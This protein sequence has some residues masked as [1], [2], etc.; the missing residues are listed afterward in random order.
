M[1]HLLA[2]AL[3]CAPLG[4]DP[5][6]QI[7]WI[8]L[9]RRLQEDAQTLARAGVKLD[10]A[11]LQLEKLPPGELAKALAAREA[12]QNGA[13]WYEMLWV[14]ARALG[15]RVAAAPD[16]FR[17]EF[18]HA[19][20]PAQAAWYLPARKSLVFDEARYT[21]DESFHR[22]LVRELVLA[23]EDQDG[24]LATLRQSFGATSEG[25]LLARACID[26]R[27]ELIA[28]GLTR[29]LELSPPSALEERLGG[30][31]ILQRCGLLEAARQES[32]PVEKRARPAS[33]AQLLHRPHKDTQPPT[34]VALPALEPAASVLV[35]EDTLGEA[36][37]R[38]VLSLTTLDPLRALE[39]AVGWSG[40]R[41]R[42][43]RIGTSVHEFAWRI[44]FDRELDAQQLESLLHGRV[45]GRV[46][47][48]GATRVWSWESYEDHV[49]G[50][51]ERLAA[52]PEP[53]PRAASCASSTETIERELLAA[54]PHREGERW[55]LPERGL[56]LVLG[57]GW[58]PEFFQGQPILYHGAAADG[59]RDNVT[60]REYA[61][62]AAA[63]I[64]RTR[65]EV[66]QSFAAAPNAKLLRAEIVEAAGEK[67]LLLEYTQTLAGRALHQLELQLLGGGRKLAL[68]GTM[69]EAHGKALGE[70]LLALLCSVKR[71][72]RTPTAEVPK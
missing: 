33:S 70:P 56:S 15:L 20:L 10:L 54:Q 8:A 51:A 40:D 64:E 66:Q 27:A 63:T 58:D 52:V 23:S 38:L 5:A 53:A 65:D 16:A 60:F 61:V 31:P 62:D 41:L 59:F 12:E 28:R 24:S 2:L 30:I 69:L 46:A 14:L 19:T 3:A 48:P 37:L 6:P 36:G 71:L 43:W 34:E 25:Q 26:G 72:P 29:T 21:D 57:A 13:G 42:V 11:R 18:Q 9:T 44:A 47:R 22:V 67:A 35:R 49:A 1:Q 50:I 4:Q 45:Q 68:T 17:D 55:L 7:D 39:A 32:L